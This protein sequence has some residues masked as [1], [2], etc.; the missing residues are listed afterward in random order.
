MPS[1]YKGKSRGA[2]SRGSNG[3]A[4]MGD[5][6]AVARVIGK[7]PVDGNDEAG[8]RRR[9]VAEFC[10]LI[11]ADLGQGN[12]AAGARGK[13]VSAGLGLSPRVRETLGGLLGGDQEK[14]IANRMG[15]SRHTVHVY[16]KQ[17][18]RKFNVSSRGEL[19]ARFVRGI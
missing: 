19:L 9:L 13:A 10:K 8:R 1:K 15:V 12:G 7:L 4:R 18:Y 3:A 11:G 14:E 5:V 2:S 16:V 6:A 17:L